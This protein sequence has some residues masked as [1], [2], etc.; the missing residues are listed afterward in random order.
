MGEERAVIG[1][2]E[3]VVREDIDVEA[4]RIRNALLESENKVEDEFAYLESSVDRS[5]TTV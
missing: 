1:K 4:E 2:S 3:V 5:I